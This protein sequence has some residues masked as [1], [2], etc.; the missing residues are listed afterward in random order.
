MIVE[1]FMAGKQIW[2]VVNVGNRLVKIRE[3][4]QCWKNTRGQSVPVHLQHVP[5]HLCRKVAVGKVY[6]YTFNMYRYTCAE[7]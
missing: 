1:R 4:Q 3:L 6:R 2:I 5:V 7:K